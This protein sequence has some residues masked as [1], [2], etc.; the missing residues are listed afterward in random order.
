[1]QTSTGNLQSAAG[2]RLILRPFRSRGKAEPP[3]LEATL[4]E[5]I[6]YGAKFMS[7]NLLRAYPRSHNQG[8]LRVSHLF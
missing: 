7:S 6:N 1:M 4:D 5:R 8:P 2:F 3:R